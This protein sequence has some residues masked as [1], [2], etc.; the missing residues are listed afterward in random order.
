VGEFG[1]DG[2]E[3][4]AGFDGVGC[5]CLQGGAIEGV[6]EVEEQRLWER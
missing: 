1:G 5:L 3:D 6:V 2:G 4:R